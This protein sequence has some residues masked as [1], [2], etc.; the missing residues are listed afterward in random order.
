MAIT[1]ALASH[2]SPLQF[3][4]DALL[5]K[6]R[7]RSEIAAETLPT[8]EPVARTCRSNKLCKQLVHRTCTDRAMR[9]VR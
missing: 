8:R 5:T 1:P 4:A 6:Y 3:Q 9:L 2:P 7:L